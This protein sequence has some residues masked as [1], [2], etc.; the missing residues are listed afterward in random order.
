MKFTCI[1][2]TDAEWAA[3]EDEQAQAK[4]LAQSEA[5]DCIASFEDVLTEDEWDT[6]NERFYRCHFAGDYEDL[7]GDICEACL[8][9]SVPIE[10][11]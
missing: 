5:S 7:V 10:S 3:W 6:F 4:E 1:F 9:R 2:P 8:G 11:A